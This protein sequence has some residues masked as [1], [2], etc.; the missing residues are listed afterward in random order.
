MKL[1]KSHDAEVLSVSSPFP[2]VPYKKTREILRT[3][4]NTSTTINSRERQSEA[5]RAIARISEA[6]YTEAIVVSNA[7]FLQVTR[8]S[9]QQVNKQSLL[10]LPPRGV[11]SCLLLYFQHVLPPLPSFREKLDVLRS[12]RRINKYE[13]VPA[14]AFSKNKYGGPYVAFCSTTTCDSAPQSGCINSQETS[15]VLFC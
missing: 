2:S 14:R 1:G 7:L 11:L 6:I 4:K 9:P 5:Q 15:T 3:C 12:Q 8:S 13:N 10:S